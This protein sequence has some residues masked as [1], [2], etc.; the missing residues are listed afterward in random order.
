[1]VDSAQFDVI[2]WTVTGRAVHEYDH[3][4]YSARRAPTTQAFLRVFST[5]ANRRNAAALW[6]PAS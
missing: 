2:A 6:P 1:M 4:L 3:V 5:P